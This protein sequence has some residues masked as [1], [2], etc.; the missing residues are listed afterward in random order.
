MR[1]TACLCRLSVLGT[2]VNACLL[3]ALLL[4]AL[5]ACDRGGPTAEPTDA[6]EAARDA[7]PT[8]RET[9]GRTDNDATATPE[10]TSEPEPTRRGIFGRTDSDATATPEPTD[11]P[12]PTRRP[13]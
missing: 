1:I 8:R 2:S 6:R 9:P 7:E 4:A 12:E 11:E 5:A 3:A 10:P 13:P